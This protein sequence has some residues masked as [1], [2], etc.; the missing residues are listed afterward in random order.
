MLSL[1]FASVTLAASAADDSAAVALTHVTV[2]VGNGKVV[3]DA[4]VVVRDGTI[5]QVGRTAAVPGDAQVVDGKGL[6]VYPGLIDALREQSAGGSADPKAKPEDPPA[7]LAYSQVD[8]A[9]VDD[10]SDAAW[11]KGGVLAASVAPDKGIFRGQSRVRLLGGAAGAPDLKSPPAFNVSLRGLGYHNRKPGMREPGGPFPNRL[12]GVLGFV[13]QTVLDARYLQTAAA[14]GREI[15]VE[16]SDAELRRNLSALAPAVNGKA[17]MIL[18]AVSDREFRRVLRLVDDLDI[19][20]ILAGGHGADAVAAQLAARRIPL[21]YS[22]HFIDDDGDVHADYSVPV[23]VLRERWQAPRSAATLARAGVPLAFYS[24]GLQQGQD[25]LSG[26]RRVV[27]AGLDEKAALRAATLGAAELLGVQSRLGSIEAGKIANLV[28]TDGN[29]FA[30]ETAIRMVFVGGRRYADPQGWRAKPTPEPF[31]A[32]IP[33][34]FANLIP[35]LGPVVLVR[36]VNIMTVTHGTLEGTSMLVKDGKI[37]ALGAQLKAP[38]GAHVIDGTGK[39]IT[40]GLIDAHSH[41]ANDSHNDSGSNET[42]LANMRD[43]IDSGDMAVYR[44]LSAGVTAANLLHGSVNPIGGQTVVIKNRWGVTGDEM[45][46]AGARPGLK[47]AIKEFAPREGASPPATLMGMEAFLRD[48]L[49]RAQHYAQEWDAYEKRKA[50]G[51][52]QLVAPRRNLRLDPIVE[53]MRGKRD[54]HVHLYTP[55][56]ITLM[57]RLADEF[58]FK[59]RVFQHATQGYKVAAAIAR[60]GGGASIFSDHGEANLYNAAILGSHGVVVSINSDNEQ[61]ARNF[62]QQVARQRKYGGFSENEALAL[63]T[64]NPA[65]QLGIDQRVGSI[66]LGKDADFVLFDRHPLSIYAVPQMVF[67]DG[68]LQFSLEAERRRQQQVDAIHAA[69]R[70]A[71][72]EKE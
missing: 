12:V 62:L 20:P 25:F 9:K 38:Q 44:T 52:K 39:W 28:V 17:P 6:F 3:N 68:K 70:A 34:T 16:L 21:F 22:L 57:I 35:D 63:V 59:V 27:R 54:L 58:G 55:E 2:V 40:P 46:F 29:L 56:E 5:Q 36:N 69:R 41:I 19:K 7:L 18:P 67:I 50:S 15:P 8:T 4:T 42:S 65:K 43:T 13:R 51:A 26:L 32:E 45:L 31:P 71:H 10:A 11:R 1:L 48:A 53:V 23:S 37:A 33:D 61:W 14:A 30:D 24:D 49:T 72:Q 47:F 60:H 64:L 66:D